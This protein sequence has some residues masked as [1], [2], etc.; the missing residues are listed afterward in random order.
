MSILK[1]F[2]FY[3][4]SLWLM[5]L[6]F[7]LSI[8]L[9]FAWY[10][11][12]FLF[13]VF[14][15]SFWRFRILFCVVVIFF[16]FYFSTSIYFF[17]VRCLFFFFFLPI[18]CISIVF[19]F[20]TILHSCLLLFAT[21]K[22]CICDILLGRFLGLLMDIFSPSVFLFM[23]GLLCYR[24]ISSNLANFL[25]LI[26]RL[27]VFYDIILTMLVSTLRFFAPFYLS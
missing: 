21:F 11:F 4:H 16:L 10:S 22:Y 25:F 5:N 9:Y 27:S 12:L 26:S 20:F 17:W 24:F 7:V 15:H 2:V 19:F 18:L 6:I 14:D 3:V 1:V 8:N 23:I 13:V